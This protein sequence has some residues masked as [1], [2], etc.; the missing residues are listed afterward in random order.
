MSAKAAA[1][2]PCNTETEEGTVALQKK[3]SRRVSFAEITSVHVFDRDDEYETPPEPRPSSENEDE[4]GFLRFL[5]DGEESSQNEEKVEGKE[6]DDELED[7][8]RSFFRPFESPSPGSTIGSAT[9]NDE[10]NFFGPVSASFIQHGRFSDSAASD[11]NHD[12]TLDSTAFS[13]HFRSLARSDSGG[14]LKTPMG[15]HLSFEE[16][17]PTQNTV[18]A[19]IGSSMVLTV[20]KPISESSTSVDK[21]SGCRYSNDMSL[22]GESPQRYDYGRLSPGLDALLAEG[23]KDLHAVSVLDNR[24][25]SESSIKLKN[26]SSPSKKQSGLIE[27]VDGREKELGSIDSA[28]LDDANGGCNVSPLGKITSGLSDM[29]NTPASDV[30]VDKQ[31]WSPS[32]LTEGLTC[33]KT[34]DSDALEIRRPNSDC[35]AAICESQS[36]L[37]NK[38]Q[39]T[40]VFASSGYET[41]PAPA[42]SSL[43]AKQRLIVLNNDSPLQNLQI[44]TPF[45]IQQSSF[46]RDLTR[47]QSEIV[48]SI[49]KSIS[50]LKML[51]ASP[52]SSSLKVNNGST[53]IPLD[54][55]KSTV[56]NTVLD[57]DREDVQM[58]CV[59][60]AVA[61]SEDRLFIVATEN[62][63]LKSSIDM[64]ASDIETVENKVD[65]SHAKSSLGVAEDGIS[66]GHISSGFFPKLKEEEGLLS[67]ITW[68]GTKMLKNLLTPGDPSEGM[69]FTSAEDSSFMEIMLD[70]SNN[71]KTTGTP[72]RTLPSS[73]KIME[74][75]SI[76]SEKYRARDR[77]P[78]DQVSKSA[79]VNPGRDADSRDNVRNASPFTINKSDSLFLDTAL[80]SSPV[81]E[82][83][84][85]KESI[86]LESM[87]D[88]GNFQTPLSDKDT[89]EVHSMIVNGNLDVDNPVRLKEL[90][91]GGVKVSSLGSASPVVHRGG[92]ELQ[93]QKFNM[94]QVVKLVTPSPSRK[95]NHNAA[96][97]DKLHSVMVEGILSPNSNY[98]T[99][100][101]GN[102]YARK[103]RREDTIPGNSALLDEISRIRR[104]PKH[105]RSDVVSESF[106]EQPS[107]S[108]TETSTVGRDGEAR[109]QHW[110]DIAVLED[111]LVNL[112]RVQIYETLCAEVRSQNKLQLLS[113][114][115]QESQ[116]LKLK[117]LPRLSVPCT[118][119]ACVESV[120]NNHHQSVN[121]E[122]TQEEEV[123]GNKVTALRQVLDDSERKV[124]SLCKS[125]L[126]S[127]KK[128]EQTNS[129]D[130]IL[131][132]SDQLKKK[133]CCRFMRLDMQLWDVD[134][135]ETANDHHN[136]VLNYLGFIIQRF[137]INV[138]PVSRIVIS[139]K[140]NDVNISKIT[141]SVLGNLLD[142]VQE[143]QGASVELQNLTYTSFHST[144]DIH[145]V[146][147]CS[148]LNCT[149]FLPA[150]E[151]LELHLHFIDFNS[152]RKAVLSIDMSCLKWGIYPSDAVPA[153]PPQ[154]EGPPDVSRKLLPEPQ[155]AEIRAAVQSLRVGYSRI[156]RLCRCVSELVQ[157]W[158]W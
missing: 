42:L 35:D 88:I 70:P 113:S 5:A 69:V 44:T 139:N 124:M 114:G 7:G 86:R 53:L 108:S 63:E 12:I 156:M 140:P 128:Q 4:L 85:P 28:E 18:P 131:F 148:E 3:R 52:F 38:A 83:N 29:R 77:R 24:P 149:L 115:I 126:N 56:Y 155:L 138:G 33:A 15:V 8:R 144:S 109:V 118:R 64:D 49:Q 153:V 51:N 21:L 84:H 104:S 79:D 17:T 11:E 150:V 96:H 20:A 73:E 37:D 78:Y 58:E 145:M 151:Q 122:G 103:R 9:S 89:K 31:C 41:P 16:K 26:R 10:D 60:T 39:R 135:L 152:G 111:V 110:A 141:S 74:K 106:S 25:F 59:D 132:V 14:D 119:D 30:S 76:A 40:D 67:Q 47:K 34:K 1:D 99:D 142:V 107:E 95:E 91:M 130:T 55:F 72:H 68:S 120:D 80:S 61:C 54:I 19:N 146:A 23:S 100:S 154:L 32:Q 129:A 93:N 157:T 133:A 48:S 27:P 87:D 136:I 102:F 123:S 50:K 143:V 101:F 75:A 57:R 158:S 22:V 90:T 127:S 81:M 36:Y 92:I 112:R 2:D 82:I 46:V 71:K 6:E 98:L 65:V 117:F 125:F 43:S 94:Q 137:T 45:E 62:G 105:H 147:T 66:P 116:M 134:N 97:N 13:M 121:F